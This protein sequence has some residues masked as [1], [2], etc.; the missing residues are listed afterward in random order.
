MCGAQ[1]KGALARVCRRLALLRTTKASAP[2]PD[3]CEG[4]SWAVR[5]TPSRLTAGDVERT[6]TKPID[7]VRNNAC[8]NIGACTCPAR[9]SPT[10]TA[11]SQGP[12]VR[13]AERH[14]MHSGRRR[15]W[16]EGTCFIWKGPPVRI[17]PAEQR[18]QRRHLHHEKARRDA[19]Q[20]SRTSDARLLRKWASLLWP[21]RTLDM[22]P[23][24]L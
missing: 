4:H 24:R 22:R 5:P 7:R 17:K 3:L 15:L 10:C 18:H 13:G 8:G 2:R 21:R 14:T 20:A 12:H 9:G 6:C 11:K 19:A 16:S 23:V 1:L